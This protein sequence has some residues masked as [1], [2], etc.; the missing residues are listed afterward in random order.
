MSRDLAAAERLLRECRLAMRRKR[1]IPSERRMVLGKLDEW[2]A[3]RPYF[4][5]ARAAAGEKED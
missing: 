4:D 1:M 5:R 2:L 3:P